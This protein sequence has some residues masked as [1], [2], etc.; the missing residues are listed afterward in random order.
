MNSRFLVIV[1]TDTMGHVVL[2]ATAKEEVVKE[3]VL[4]REVRI[5]ARI[6]K[7][8]SATTKPE[9]EILHVEPL[10][11]K[12]EPDGAANGSQPIRSETNRTSGAAGSRR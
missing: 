4:G 10:K 1:T 11:S 2:Q 3:S 7:A 6:T 12:V 5:T 8:G 9:L